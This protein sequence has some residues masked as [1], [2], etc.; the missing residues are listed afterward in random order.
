MKTSHHDLLDTAADRA[1][2]KCLEGKKSFAVIAGAGSGKT[3][4]LILALEHLRDTVGSRLRRDDMQIA[5]ITYTNRAADVISSRLDWDDL[6]FVSTLHSF[7]WSQ[8]K[9]FTP[10]IREALRENVIPTQIERKKEEDN[11]GQSRR[12]I[13]AREKITSLQ[14]DLEAL[15]SV[16]VFDY[17]D[18]KFSDYS[19]GRLN[20][21]DVIDIASY[22]LAENMILRRI[23]GQKYPYIFVD[24]AQ[25]TFSS[26]V[27]A[28]NTLCEGE[29]LPLVGYFGDPMQQIYDKRAGD[30]AGPVGS[31][32]ITKQ[33]NFRCSLKVI[34]L[35]NNFR[36]DVQQVAAGDNANVEGSV[37]LALVQAETP[38][39]PRN[40]YT[41]EQVVRASDRFSRV[42]QSWGWQKRDGVIQLFLARQM[43]ARRLGFPN[44]NSLFTGQF[45]SSRAQDDYEKGVHFLLTPFAKFLSPLMQTH[46][47][48]DTG[49]VLDLLRTSSPA[50]DPD[51]VNAT[52]TLADMMKDMDELL[53]Q[54]QRRWKGDKLGSILK[55][56][57]AKNICKVPERLADHLERE[58]RTEEYDRDVHTN[59]KGDWLADAFFAMTTTEVDA[60]VSFI[61]ENTPFSTQHGVKGEQYKD[62]VV[63][64][65]DTEAAWNNYSFTKALTPNTSGNPTEGQLDRSRKLAYVCFSRAQ[66]NLRI[67][68]FTRNPQEAREE[69]IS[70][71]LFAD[72]Q[73]CIIE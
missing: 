61:N 15:D 46:L 40:R 19:N 8:V 18:T 17:D 32:N 16:D 48:G 30:F 36:K 21:G 20:H 66:E 24:E 25:D 65:D 71:Q 37:L 2:R 43:I 68:L 54:L 27:T 56:C 55:Y 51:G 31:V 42:M 5:C 4:S 62:V 58:T 67:L 38:G 73:I 41:E 52:R 49:Q 12:A 45:A 3:T 34:E 57:N 50:F 1:I 28:L 29:G 14:A 63:V 69:L 6:F 33:E 7:L 11:G 44:L 9:R 22:L 72:A 47:D 10:N 53:E 70:N 26:V 59:D 64:F 39:A 23:V 35:L 13:A 60:Y